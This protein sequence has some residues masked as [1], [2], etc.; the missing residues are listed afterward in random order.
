M[1]KAFSEYEKEMIRKRLLEQGYRL[2]SIYGLKKTNIDEIAKAAGISKGAFYSF[3]PSKEALFMDVIERAES[4]IRQQV[5]S[6]IELPGP[7]ARARLFAVLKKAFSLFREI[8]ILQFVTGADYEIIFGRIPVEKL[9]K[10]LEND[11]LFI[12]E[13]FARCREAGIPLRVSPEQLIELL[14]PL[15]LSIIAEDDFRK[16]GFSGNLDLLLELIAAYCLGEMSLQLNGEVHRQ[17][18]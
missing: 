14:Y 11:R 17:G 12:D 18:S 16:F 2:F 10:H 4:Q 8:P 15:A 9:Q 1:S 3:Y 5:L 6:A 7:S 13:L